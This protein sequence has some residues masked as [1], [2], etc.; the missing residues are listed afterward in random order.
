MEPDQWEAICLHLDLAF[1]G[2][3]DDAKGAA[4]HTFLGHLEA[5][6]VMGAVQVLA[7]GGARFT[8]S[9]GEIL[10]VLD[11]LHGPPSFDVA[12]AAIT[13]AMA[14]YGAWRDVETATRVLQAGS[15]P[16]VLDWVETYGWARLAREPVY[17]PEHGGAVIH[18]LGK[19]Y[20]EHVAE[21]RLRERAERRGLPGAAVHQLEEKT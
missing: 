2:E 20:T 6:A 7:D 15:H 5:D 18:R 11:R 13:L 10:G 14:S 3:W 17:D 1:A 19:S 9:V 12:W 21:Y 8:P 16:A 4:Y